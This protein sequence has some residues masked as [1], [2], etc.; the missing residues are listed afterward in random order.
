FNASVEAARA[1]EHGK[2]FAV[3]AEEVGNLAQ[4]SGVAAREIETMLSN[5]IGQVESVIRETNDSVSRLIE[6]GKSKVESGVAIAARCEEVL[7]DVVR[8]VAEVKSM[9]GEVAH[10]SH[11]QAE[12]VNNITTAMNQL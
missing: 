3:V 6:S 10:G 2:G 9:M 11:E 7:D 1:G 8:N 5:S 4:M 12:G